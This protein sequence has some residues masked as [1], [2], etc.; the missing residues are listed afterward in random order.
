MGL[1]LCKLSSILYKD[2]GWC[3]WSKRW[4]LEEWFLK[5]HQNYLNSNHLPHTPTWQI[6]ISRVK[7]LG[8]CNRE[9]FT[10]RPWCR[11]AVQMTSVWEP[12]D[13]KADLREPL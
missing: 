2:A 4:R 3:Y 6:R 8:I 7:G 10:G 13:E 12:Q 11:Q 5:P 9:I 1:Q